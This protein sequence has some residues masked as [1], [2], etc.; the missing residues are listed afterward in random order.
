MTDSF[1]RS[2]QNL[3]EWAAVNQ[4]TREEARQRLAQFVLLRGIA[5]SPLLQRCMVF[6]GGNAL[7]FFWQPNRS[8]LDLD[9]SLDNDASR[10][11]VSAESIEAL[12]RATGNRGV[13]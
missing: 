1:P 11:D 3:N 5:S 7:D 8:T 13:I 9:F 2:F 10:F 4:I 6:K 12:L